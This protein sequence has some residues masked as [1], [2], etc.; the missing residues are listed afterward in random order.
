[1]LLLHASSTRINPV[2]PLGMNNLQHG[3]AWWDGWFLGLCRYIATASKDPSTQN[4]CVVVGP[5]REIRSTGFNGLP[6]GVKDTDDRLNNRELKMQ[7]ICHAEENAV[8]HAARI[9]VSL[10]GCTLY[11]TWPP[12]IRCARAIIQAGIIRVVSPAGVVIPLRW[13]ADFA[14]SQDIMDEAGIYFGT[15]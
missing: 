1:M 3:L 11:C 8:S 10:K 5:D 13:Q 15:A 14:L 4:G 2:Y 7:L 6:R 12:C 9:G